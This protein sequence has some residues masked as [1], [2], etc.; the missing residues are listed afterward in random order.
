MMQPC[1]PLPAAFERRTAPLFR[2]PRPKIKL[3]SCFSSAPEANH[4]EE[5][6]GRCLLHDGKNP[7][8][9]AVD[10]ANAVFGIVSRVE[11]GETPIAST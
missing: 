3:L 8:S 7:G 4:T 9:F 2:L 10:I 6:R 5:W 11:R 1:L